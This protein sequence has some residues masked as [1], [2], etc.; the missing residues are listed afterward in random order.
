MAINV[1][2]N[3]IAK[4]S[5]AGVQLLAI[6]IAIKILGISQYVAYATVVAIATWPVLFMINFGPRLIA[7]ISACNAP[8]KHRDIFQSSVK[9]VTLNVAAVAICM[10]CVQVLFPVEQVFPKLEA[11]EG[12]RASRLAIVIATASILSG[13]FAIPETFQT[14]FQKLYILSVVTI[15]GNITSLVFIVCVLPTYP[16]IEGL[17]VALLAPTFL[18]RLANSLLF[19]ANHTYLFENIA[20]GVAKSQFINID[21]RDGIA[22]SLIT[23]IASYLCNQLPLL[24]LTKYGTNDKAALYATLL[25]LLGMLLQPIS[26]L[27][28]PFIPA[29]ATHLVSDDVHWVKRTIGRLGLIVSVYGTVLVLCLSAYGPLLYSRWSVELQASTSLMFF[30]G[31]YIFSVCA[32]SLLFWLCHITGSV[33]HCYQLYTLRSFATVLT[34]S[35]LCFGLGLEAYFAIVTLTTTCIMVMPLARVIQKRITDDR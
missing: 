4:L 17:A 5:G 2:A 8:S 11:M 35:G 23:G 13:F 3:F 15:I 6:P 28:T 32:E 12:W 26:L 22:F 10:L 19:I 14:S 7:R 34:A 30:F 20:E 27:I 25:S 21:F 33:R 31:T 1:A 9:T 18:S 16:T 29:I 24:L